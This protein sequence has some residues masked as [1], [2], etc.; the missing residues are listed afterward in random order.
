MT[1]RGINRATVLGYLGKD[2]HITTTVNGGLRAH[3]SI[4]TT[5]TWQNE[6][7][8]TVERT[9]WHQIV[10]FGRFAEVIRDHCQKRT[11][12]YVEGPMQTRQ[13]IDGD[14]MKHF[15]TEIIAHN[16]QFVANA[17]GERFPPPW[18]EKQDSSENPG[19]QSDAVDAVPDEI[20][21][22]DDLLQ[23]NEP[24]A[25]DDINPDTRN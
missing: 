2:P 3:I 9:D 19:E 5:E 23:P 7:D 18:G 4:A 11:K 24:F 20:P 25:Y 12:L 1:T 10:A 8:E 16:I 13:W 6:N 15:R 14:G 17:G 21:P 22:M